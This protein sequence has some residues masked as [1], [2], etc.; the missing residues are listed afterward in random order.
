MLNTNIHESSKLAYD[1]QKGMLDTLSPGFT[2][3]KDLGVKQAPFYVLIGAN[4]PAILLETGFI[5]NPV[6]RKRLQ[7]S[8]YLETLAAGMVAGIRQYKESITQTSAEY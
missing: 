5:T 3:V 1:I 7:S 2:P 8:E 4:M 6:E